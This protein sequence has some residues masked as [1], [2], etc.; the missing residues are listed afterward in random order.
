MIEIDN[1]GQISAE[2]LLLIVVLLLI[3]A[4]VTIPLVGRSIDASN[5]ISWASDANIAVDSIVNAV[6]IVYSNGPNSKRSL[7]FYIPETMNF[8]TNGKTVSLSVA[9]SNGTTHYVNSTTNYPMNTNNQVLTKGKWY[10]ATI[11]WNSRS[12][13]NVNVIAA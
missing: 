9:L 11:T 1:K 13:I 8:Q 10:N 6:N 2:Y 12:N 4:T 5:D 7:N 3:M